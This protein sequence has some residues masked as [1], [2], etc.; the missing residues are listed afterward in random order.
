MKI[1]VKLKEPVSHGS[2]T[3]DKLEIRKPK[4]KDIRQLPTDPKTGDILDL[5]A[6]LADQPPSVINE[7]GM[8]DVE[9]VLE[10]VGGFFQRGLGTGGR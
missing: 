2:E 3:I 8:E 7:L 10:V 9:A 1:E 5:A 4:A 6:R